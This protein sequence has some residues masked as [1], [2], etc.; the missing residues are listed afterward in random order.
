MAG[1]KPEIASK[2]S[3]LLS[4]E[5]GKVR[6]AASEM[7]K[8]NSPAATPCCNQAKIFCLNSKIISV[9]FSFPVNPGLRA[10]TVTCNF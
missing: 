3:H 9:L 7:D 10:V 5:A 1:L 6:W 8:G 4:V 2:L